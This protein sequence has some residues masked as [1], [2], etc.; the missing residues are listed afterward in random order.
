MYVKIIFT[1]NYEQGHPLY[2][3]AIACYHTRRPRRYMEENAKVVLLEKIDYLFNP[4]VTNEMFFVGVE[5]IPDREA[6]EEKL[7]CPEYPEVLEK[8]IWKHHAD[9]IPKKFEEVEKV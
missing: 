1:L 3:D 5:Y 6:K 7:E 9:E 2:I 8:V 4:D